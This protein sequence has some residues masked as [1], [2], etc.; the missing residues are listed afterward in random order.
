MTH[1]Y[2]NPDG[3][4]CPCGCE[5]QTK[6]AERITA[7]PGDT[8]LIKVPRNLWP[9]FISKGNADFSTAVHWI[10]DQGSLGTCWYFAATGAH[11]IARYVQGYGHTLLDCS[12]GPATIGGTNGAPIERAILDV[13]IPRGQPPAGTITG[14]DPLTGRYEL[15][16]RAWP[17]DWASHAAQHRALNWLRCQDVDDLVSGLFGGHPG[18]FGCP[19]PR[20]GHAVAVARLEHA[21]RGFA[22]A[23][24]NSWS[25]RFTAGY[26][27][28][29]PERPGWW[30]LSLDAVAAGIRT[31]G[32]YILAAVTPGETAPVEPDP[33][34]V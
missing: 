26:G 7:F 11:Q 14:S 6:T 9:D 17:S 8:P 1:Y 20:G 28:Y 5:P 15:N 31:Y 18:V 34:N 27:A 3:H 19:W 32:A 4:Q 10:L 24:P 25:T 13:L 30:R 23:G 29:G 21:G 12:T 33:T 16:P 2:E 22:L